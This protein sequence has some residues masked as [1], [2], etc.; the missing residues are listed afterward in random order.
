MQA[1]KRG[2][3]EEKPFLPSRFIIH[4]YKTVK[5]L[6]RQGDSHKNHLLNSHTYSTYIYTYV[7]VCLYVCMSIDHGFLKK[8]ELFV[9]RHGASVVIKQARIKMQCEGG[10][11]KKKMLRCLS[12]LTST[13]RGG[14]HPPWS[15]CP[16]EINGDTS[17]R[18]LRRG[19]IRT[20]TDVHV[21]ICM[22]PKL[23]VSYVVII[24]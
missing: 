22:C 13:V 12:R 8:M 21:Y 10:R 17:S 14:W 6:P 5:I 18:V 4:R 23:L 19:Y 9:V 2:N 24:S 3:G 15:R 20:H 11:G 7:H 16:T 1:R